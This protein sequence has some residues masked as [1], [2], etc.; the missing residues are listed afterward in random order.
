MRRMLNFN[1]TKFEIFIWIFSLIILSV[2]YLLTDST[3]LFLLSTMIGVTALVFLAKGEPLGQV[4][5][6][7]FST[8]YAIIA[9]ELRYYSEVITYLGMTMPSA[10]IALLIWLKNP[11]LK[12]KSVVR[13]EKL[14]RKKILVSLV[15]TP[16]VTSLFFLVLK[17]L[18]T[19][20]LLISTISIATSFLAALMMFFRSRHYAIFYALNDLV[21]I[22]LWLLATGKDLSYF[23]MVICFIIFFINDSYAYF[24][25][26]KLNIIQ[27]GSLTS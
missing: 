12:N 26:K 20:Y 2:S 17:N 5:T 10:F 18:S 23:P 19:P 6:I 13:I 15:L 24:S 3:L 9:Y 4:L 11:F 22:I 27:M 7:I 14:T 21:L 8:L 1:L 25:W 16:V